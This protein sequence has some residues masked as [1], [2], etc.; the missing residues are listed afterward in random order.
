MKPA[1]VSWTKKDSCDLGVHHA[2]FNRSM[3]SKNWP[4]HNSDF[5]PL[6]DACS[7]DDTEDARVPTGKSN[8]FMDAQTVQNSVWYE[9]TITV[10]TLEQ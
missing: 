6:I 9:L 8:A 3:W 1:R 2:S 10:I 4:F 7:W 5:P